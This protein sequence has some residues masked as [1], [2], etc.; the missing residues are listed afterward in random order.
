MACLNHLVPKS[1]EAI[2]VGATNGAHRTLWY[3]TKEVSQESLIIGALE[4]A[5]WEMDHQI[6]TN[7]Q[8]GNFRIFLSFR[9]SVKSISGILEVEKLPFLQFHKL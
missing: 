1:A 4:A 3:P 5:F 2:D 6:G 7:A 8:C 9:I